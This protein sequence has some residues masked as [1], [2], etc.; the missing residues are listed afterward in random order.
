MNS[1]LFIRL[2]GYAAGLAAL[3]F[4]GLGL[5]HMAILLAGNR[6]LPASWS[7]QALQLSQNPGLYGLAAWAMAL[8]ILLALVVALQLS[9]LVYKA[10]PGWVRWSVTLVL[11][12][13]AIA[14][15]KEITDLTLALRQAQVYVGGDPLTLGAFKALEQGS[16]DPDLF[17]LALLIAGWFL[18]IHLT[19]LRHAALP[20]GQGL[21]GLAYAGLLL[22]VWLTLWLGAQSLA[23]GTLALQELGVAPAWY[24]ATAF[25]LRRQSDQII[26]VEE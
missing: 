1:R 26:Q 23:M 16:F 3:L 12:G 11:A 13:Y 24:L 6:V 10:G 19:G 22:P 8:P 5:V 18:V 17:L 15:I 21:L 9:E 20:L 14:V 7:T 25:L 2:G 4:F